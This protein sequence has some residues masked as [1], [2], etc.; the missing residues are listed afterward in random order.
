MFQHLTGEDWAQFEKKHYQAYMFLL[1]RS[2]INEKRNCEIEL[3]GPCL[4]KRRIWLQKRLEELT[5]AG[6]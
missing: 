4:E 5:A 1:R 6:I 3:T 2:L